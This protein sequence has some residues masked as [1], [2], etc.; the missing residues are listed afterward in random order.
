MSKLRDIAI[1]KGVSNTALNEIATYELFGLDKTI[2]SLYNDGKKGHRNPSNSLLAYELEITDKEPEDKFALMYDRQQEPDIDLDY[3]QDAREIA[4]N[5]VKEKYG[6]DR[7]ANI[8]THTTFGMKTAF[9]DI[10][11]VLG[12]DYKKA[13]AVAMH[14]FGKYDGI[15][16]E[17][18]MKEFFSSA[19]DESRLD[20]DEFIHEE[21]LPKASYIE[22]T[23]EFCSIVDG[24]IGA[25]KSSSIHACGIAIS[26]EPLADYIPLRTDNDG[27]PCTQLPSKDVEK[28]CAKVDLL[29]ISTLDII[30]GVMKR[31]GITEV[32]L[33]P[34]DLDFGTM[35]MI[36]AG[37]T[38]G[39]FQIGTRGISNLCQRVGANPD[40]LQNIDDI[41]ALC[42]LY[43]PGPIDSG[44]MEQYCKCALGEPVPPYI[45]PSLEP[46]LKYN[47]G[48]ILYQE[49]IMRIAV[50]IAGYSPEESDLMRYAIG[51]KIEADLVIHE[52]KF[53]D[54]CVEKSGFTPEQAKELWNNILTFARYGFNKSHAVAYAYVAYITAWLKYNYRTYFYT[55][56]LNTR[57]SA[58]DVAFTIQKAESESANIKVAPP[59]INSSGIGFLP[60]DERTIIYGLED[61][62]GIGHITAQNILE[63]RPE[64]GYTDIKDFIINAPPKVT[65]SVLEKMCWSG[66]LDTLSDDNSG[67]LV[68]RNR[69]FAEIEAY[70]NIKKDNV[71]RSKLKTEANRVQQ[72]YELP[73]DFE[74]AM[75]GLRDVC[76]KEKEAIG[77]Y[78]TAHPTDIVPELVGTYKVGSRTERSYYAREGYDLVCLVKSSSTLTS[79]KNKN[80]YIRGIVEDGTGDA[81]FFLFDGR[82]NDKGKVKE[83]VGKLAVGTMIC[84]HVGGHLEESPDKIVFREVTVITNDM[85]EDLGVNKNE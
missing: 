32:P 4:A 82:G 13:Q 81:M 10:C 30:N 75:F 16:K 66:A 65:R 20:V 38:F 74:P 60:F 6:A 36:R 57:K 52:N 28:M 29:T 62:R 71:R 42:A 8:G 84:G 15:S 27:N 63:G 54:G 64:D 1:E 76:E 9:T 55:E 31:A 41:A 5:Y 44:M 45:H 46:I 33:E 21:V 85:L 49:D 18:T 53:R 19:S 68:K 7:V 73:E 61:I 50:E 23:E 24:L 26:S 83:N 37:E 17:P 25:L 34:F 11:S 40:A 79:K 2:I 78:V 43:R 67:A 56:Y 69:L 35:E 51:K 48:I 58:E 14:H 59:N 12:V 77:R 47:Y 22:S 80:Q 70:T 3:S 39:C 72:P